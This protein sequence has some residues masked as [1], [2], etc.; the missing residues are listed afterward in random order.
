M[1]NQVVFC[2]PLSLLGMSAILNLVFLSYL[3]LKKENYNRH[4]V[5]VA[6]FIYL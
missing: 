3:N 4:T 6:I 1:K 5:K 2:Q